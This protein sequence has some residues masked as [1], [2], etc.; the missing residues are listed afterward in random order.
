M[1]PFRLVAL[2]VSSAIS[3]IVAAA[4]S[5]PSGLRTTLGVATISRSPW[6]SSSFAASNMTPGWDWFLISTLKLA[7][8]MAVFTWAYVLARH[9]LD[10][11]EIVSAAV[12]VIA[13]V[14]HMIDPASSAGS[15][16]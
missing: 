15:Q 2:R 3:F 5:T 4:W 13:A 12:G 16:L 6:S 8:S 11:S 1:D 9:L 10:L 7:I 14:D